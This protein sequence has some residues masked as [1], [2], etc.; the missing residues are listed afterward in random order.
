MV[1]APVVGDDEEEPLMLQP[2][3]KNT[4]AMTIDTMTCVDFS[5]FV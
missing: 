4:T 5:C 2:A 3:P 1:E